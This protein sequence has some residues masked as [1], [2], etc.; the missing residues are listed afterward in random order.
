MGAP[1]DTGIG[2]PAGGGATASGCGRLR[3]AR[4]RAERGG[5]APLA[6]AASPLAMRR[7]CSMDMGAGSSSPPSVRGK[8]HLACL[9]RMLRAAA[10]YARA[11]SSAV[12]NVPSHLDPCSSHSG[13]VRHVQFDERRFTRLCV[14]DGEQVALVDDASESRRLLPS[15]TDSR[16]S[17]L[18]RPFPP[19]PLTHASVCFIFTFCD[20]LLGRYAGRNH[21]HRNICP[22]GSCRQSSIHGPA[23]TDPFIAGNNSAIM[24][25]VNSL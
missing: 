5:A 24:K 3:A 10:S 6:C 8:L 15:G 13:R 16:I 21:W 7:R 25:R 9:P 14:A 12:S 11:A 22:S 1:A 19:R 23:D 4:A 18:G 17:D 2:W 20:H